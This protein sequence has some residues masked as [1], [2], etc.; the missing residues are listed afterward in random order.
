MH[1]NGDNSYLF[2]NVTEIIKFKAK[3]SVIVPNNLCLGNVS[4]D[5]SASNMYKT[6][7][8]GYIYDFSVDYN[9]I[10]VDN[11]KDIRKYLIKKNDIVLKKCSTLSNKYLFQQ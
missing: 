7:F 3:D 9:A 8:N 10:D 2:L 11:I 6:G 1:C 5:F 4:K